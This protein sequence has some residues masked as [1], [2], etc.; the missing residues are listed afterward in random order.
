MIRKILSALLC[1]SLTALTACGITACGKP[2]V[3]EPEV[4]RITAPTLAEGDPS[5]TPVASI[6]QPPETEPPEPVEEARISFLAAGDNVIH[7]CIYMDAER[8]AT[9]ET[10]AYN[11]RPMYED[12]ADYIA[13]F[14]LAFINQ[15]T[16]MGGDELGLSGYPRFNSPQALGY[17]LCELGF[18]IV[19]IANNHM[20]DQYAKGLSGTIDF[21]HKME[22]EFGVTM[23]GGYYDAADYDTIRL[24][25]REGVKIAFLSYTYETN[26]LRLPA[27]SE[28]VVPYID[29]EDII[30]QCALAK[31]VSDFLI[32]S[33][34]WGVENS[35]TV[36][37]D[38]QRVAKLLAE[39]GTD[40][41]I[42]HHPHVL[43]RIEWI[44]SDYGETL[45]IYSLGNLVSAMMSWQNMVGGFFTF[46]IV[47][48]SDGRVYADNVG[49]TATA[50]YYGPS[51]FNSH[52]YF[53]SD[54]PA[55]KA[56][57]HGTK[58]LYNSPATPDDMRN[59]AKKIMGDFLL[60]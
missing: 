50:F 18:D 32:V 33:I 11:F 57:T 9:D 44:E 43:Q 22:D 48:M 15:E 5:D 45:C 24:I 47:R 56:A 2:A 58:M 28:L 7:P 26:G 27:S 60:E 3:S 49:F 4:T 46:D 20:V 21:W 59:F 36:S 16:L 6:T 52:I 17:D 54:Y 51:Y 37:A 42:G 41:I 34:H 31:E 12:V 30:R 55:E 8:R 29:D 35:T 53:L 19:N 1:L 14:D 38:Q 23:L 25:E 13:G 39:N 10:R 40:V